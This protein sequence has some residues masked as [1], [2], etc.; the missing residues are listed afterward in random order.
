MDYPNGYFRTPRETQTNVGVVRDLFSLYVLFSHF[1]PR[2]LPFVFFVIVMG[3][4]ARA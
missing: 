2:D 1:R 3:T 4:F